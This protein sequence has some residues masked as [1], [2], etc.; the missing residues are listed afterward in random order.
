MSASNTTG[1]S[2][3][4]ALGGISVP[5]PSAQNLDGFTANGT[6]T[7][8]TVPQTGT[9]LVTYQVSPTVAVAMS[10]Q[11]LRNGTAIP[12]SVRSPVA[13]TE[14]SATVIRALP[15][16]KKGSLLPFGGFPPFISILDTREERTRYERHQ[17]LYDCSG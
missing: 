5:L 11:V 13:T 16:L 12:G 8:F 7:S 6:D 17:P 10:S 1:Q 4:V 15:V 2:L 14:Y 3:T 9:Y